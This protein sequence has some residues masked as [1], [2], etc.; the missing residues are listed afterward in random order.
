MGEFACFIDMSPELKKYLTLCTKLFNYI[1]VC[2]FVGGR[3]WGPRISRMLGKYS[4]TELYVLP[5]S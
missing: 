4:T 1:L 5:I 2:V 3:Y